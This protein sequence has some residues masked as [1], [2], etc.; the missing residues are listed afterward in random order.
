MLAQRS[1]TVDDAGVEQVVSPSFDAVIASDGTV[2]FAII[3]TDIITVESG[4][5]SYLASYEIE[6]DAW[7]QIWEPTGVSD[8]DIGD[9]P[10][11]ITPFGDA[12]LIV[13]NNEADLPTPSA[14]F[15]Q[16]VVYMTAGVGIADKFWRCMKG[17][18]DVYR[19]VITTEGGGP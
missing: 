10:I 7:S 18:D 5:A 12:R 17:W 1:G 19:W 11:A 9:L 14:G 13:I 8:L 2:N 15:R 4:S 3:P 6:D 16:S